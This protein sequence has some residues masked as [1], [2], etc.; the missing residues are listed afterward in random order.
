MISTAQLVCTTS[1]TRMFTG[2]R[3]TDSI[4]ASTMWPPSSTGIG[5]KFRI[6]RFTFKITLNHSASCQ[7]R[8]L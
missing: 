3:R 4:S 6:A 7:P 1:S 2:L 5:S 8:S